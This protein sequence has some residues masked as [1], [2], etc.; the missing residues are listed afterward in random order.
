MAAL[1]DDRSTPM[2]AA[3]PDRIAW[4]ARADATQE[5]LVALAADE[6]EPVR[7]AVAGNP[8]APVHADHLLARDP[9][10]AIRVSLARKLAAH[11]AELGGIG[12]DRHPGLNWDALRILARDRAREVRHAVADTLA[13]M[14][15]APHDLVLDLSRDRELQVC[16]PLIRLSGVLTEA[17]LLDLVR[18]PPD[19]GSRSAVAGRL[20]LAEPVSQAI[21]ASGDRGAILA[22]LRN[23]TARIGPG[24]LALLADLAARQ[25]AL[26]EPL[27]SRP[28]WRPALAARRADLHGAFASGLPIWESQQAHAKVYVIEA[29]QI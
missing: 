14:P 25:E 27:A 11:A 17:D 22:L 1:D 16:E 3:L 15:D 9:V 18:E 21:V 20:G 29:S 7:L 19:P 10:A 13:D 8:G 28:E 12:A 5:L 24:A 23:P 6:A 4:A 26:R 2:S